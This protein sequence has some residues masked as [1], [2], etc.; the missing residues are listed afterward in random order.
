MKFPEFG[1]AQHQNENL[2]DGCKTNLKNC[3]NE[4][5]ENSAAVSGESSLC[6]E[7]G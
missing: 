6:A 5:Y 1:F 3:C 2:D 4:N 7:H